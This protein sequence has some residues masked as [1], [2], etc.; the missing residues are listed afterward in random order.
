MPNNRGKT[1][2]PRAAATPTEGSA[3]AAPAGRAEALPVSEGRPKTAAS[4]QTTSI[5]AKAMT[6]G[7]RKRREGLLQTE[8]GQ[9]DVGAGAENESAVRP[10]GRNPTRSTNGSMHR[11][12]RRRA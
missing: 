11:R 9:R 8:M 10:A 3:S 6:P 1:A 12:P 2:R 7:V 5:P 4:A